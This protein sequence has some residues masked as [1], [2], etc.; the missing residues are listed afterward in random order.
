[1]SDLNK[2][3]KEEYDKKNNTIT[4]Q[5]LIEMIEEM[6]H[7]QEAFGL[8]V[9]DTS[10]AAAQQATQ[11]GTPK[12]I[13][14]EWRPYV[15]M[16]EIKWGTATDAD[17]NVSRNMLKF[18][19]D[20]LP[21]GNIVE[22]ITEINNFLNDP[23]TA[24]GNDIGTGLS[25]MV[26]YK[27]LADII[28][29]FNA[30]AA[31]F[32][33][34]SFLSVLLDSKTG[35]QVPASA[36]ET[37]A[38]FIVYPESDGAVTRKAVSLKLYAEAG[39]KVGGSYKQLIKDLTTQYPVM[40]Y[41][42]V[43]KRVDAAAQQQ[44][45]K[46]K[47]LGSLVFYSFAFTLDNLPMVLELGVGTKKAGDQMLLATAVTDAY[48]T[49]TDIQ[50]AIDAIDAMAENGWT[51]AGAAAP[52]ADSPEAAARA[53]YGDQYSPDEDYT[54][55]DVDLQIP[56]GRQIPIKAAW[57][58]LPSIRKNTRK[59]IAAAPAVNGM[60]ALL[61]DPQKTWS[62]VT[63]T[64][65]TPQQ[66]SDAFT[67]KLG[68]MYN[69]TSED[70][71]QFGASTDLGPGG[72]LFTDGGGLG[73]KEV[74][75]ALYDHLVNQMKDKPDEQDS[76]FNTTYL[77]AT[78]DADGKVGGKRHPSAPLR[79]DSKHHA[80]RSP[81][82]K[83]I[84]AILT[85][86]SAAQ[87]ASKSRQKGQTPRQQRVAALYGA[88]SGYEA[89][90]RILKELAADSDDMVAYRK[91]LRLTAGF[92]GVGESQ[93]EI[94]GA[95]MKKIIEAG[96]SLGQGTLPYKLKKEGNIGTIP[97]TAERVTDTI[98]E[99]L[100]KMNQNLAR[101]LNAMKQMTDNINEYVAS[102]LSEPL[103]AKDAEANAV[104]V[105]DKLEKTRTEGAAAAAQN[106]DDEQ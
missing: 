82:K 95:K 31:G 28:V 4:T 78:K 20:K 69:L 99:V 5:S 61:D 56:A 50:S 26:V 47:A 68:E 89:S 9:E 24:A 106:V 42:V 36:A 33:F 64:G 92:H 105:K 40:E 55:Y 14:I 1:M 86:G 16:S 87:K 53:E 60:K 94:S 48:A 71:I 75:P 37:I 34:E 76:T 57:H 45:P 67:T 52:K 65:L 19:M 25:Y 10:S 35:H 17:S 63:N 90:L 80:S 81:L 43:V 101:A 54:T 23:A 7:L 93:F 46:S 39:V 32:I 84:E 6:M 15:P 77:N 13:T 96:N 58:G 51:T 62:A 29:D 2:I 91:A 72:R 12:P 49:T 79:S 85:Q 97:M 11:Q 41:I 102:G 27:T 70:D 59:K 100:E 83:A 104:E 103:K 73:S 88:F 98:N 66:L 44:D 38:D 74:I 30:S 3:L 8:V 18:W 21:P 22:K